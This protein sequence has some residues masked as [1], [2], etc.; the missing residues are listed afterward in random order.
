MIICTRVQ[1]RPAANVPFFGEAH[2]EAADAM[3]AFEL[4]TPGFLGFEIIHSEDNLVM[5]NRTYFESQAALYARQISIP[6][7]LRTSFVNQRE[8]YNLSNG[9]TSVITEEEV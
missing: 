4:S 1:T 3:K 2:P 7:E 6:I 5:T 8:A 9:I